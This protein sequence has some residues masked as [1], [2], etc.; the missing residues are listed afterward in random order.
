MKIGYDTIGEGTYKMHRAK[1]EL[2]KD[3][4][5]ELC[6]TVV[7]IKDTKEFLLNPKRYVIEQAKIKTGLLNIKEDK[8]LELVDLPISKIDLMVSKYQSYPV[9]L[10]A[11]VPNFEIETTNKQQETEYNALLRLCKELNSYKNT[12][13]LQLQFQFNGDILLQD[14]KWIPNYNKIKL[15]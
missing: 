14:N 2:H 10:D 1:K 8:F 5:I 3:M 15:I 9:N 6:K 4:L 13:P 7:E 12:L 11:P